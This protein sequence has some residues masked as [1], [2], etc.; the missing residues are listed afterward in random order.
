MADGPDWAVG[1]GNEGAQQTWAPRQV[2]WEEGLLWPGG[3]S[4]HWVAEREQQ[5]KA[6]G[7][8][9]TGGT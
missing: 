9:C 2:G 7:T 4:L 3:V 8:G 1:R 6:W 5:L